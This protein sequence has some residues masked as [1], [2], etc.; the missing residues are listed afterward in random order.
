MPELLLEGL[1]KVGHMDPLR[2]NVQGLVDRISI[3]LRNDLG[4]RDMKN[5]QK[6]RFT[7]E[8]FI[9]SED[10]RIE[11]VMTFVEDATGEFALTLRASTVEDLLSEDNRAMIYLLM[12]S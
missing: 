1:A 5:A 10:Y 6:Y 7:V 4:K 9:H 8:Q 3:A 12:N 2:F 11:F